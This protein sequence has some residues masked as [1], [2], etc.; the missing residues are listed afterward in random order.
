M[1]GLGLLIYPILI[2]GRRKF[3]L[4]CVVACPQV[5]LLWEFD[6]EIDV[7]FDNINWSISFGKCF[8]IDYFFTYVFICCFLAYICVHSF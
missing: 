3:E 4:V 7:I 5:V 1:R 2:M 6:V 8:S